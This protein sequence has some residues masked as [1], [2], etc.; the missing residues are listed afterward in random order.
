MLA[1]A[2]PAMGQGIALRGI[3]AVNDGMA[4]AATGCPIDAARAIDWNPASIS[5]TA[6]LGNDVRHG[7]DSAQHAGFIDA[8][9]GAFGAAGPPFAVSGS[10]K[11][12]AGV[13]PI[14]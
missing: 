2:S 5:G 3:S 13:V 4:G 11:S 8:A 6:R 12:E 9:A 14:P 1:I 7:I 10:D